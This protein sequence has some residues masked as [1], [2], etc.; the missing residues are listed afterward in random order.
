MKDVEIGV[1][2]GSGF[3]KLEG[4][5]N[6]KYIDVDTP[7]GKPTEKILIGEIEDKRVAF[8]SRHGIG[9][10]YNPSEVNYRANIYALK[11]LGVKRILSFAAVG[12]LKEEYAPQHI[13]IPDQYYDNTFKR[14]KTFFEKGIVAHVP[15]GNPFCPYLSDISYKIIKDL[16]LSVHKGGTYLN[17]EGP[18]FSTK[19]ES[20]A[21]RQLG[22]D[23]IGMTQA[24][25][26]KL[27]RE[28]EICF[29]SLCFVTDYD[30]WHE[31]FESVTVDMIIENFNKN[32]E[33]M[34]KIVKLLVK[35]IDSDTTNC[36]CANALQY[37]IVTAKDKIDKETY[38][39]LEIV[40]SK[41]FKEN[42]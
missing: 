28:L 26:A 41:Y 1:I 7:F 39:K 35:N 14:D 20:N 33:N 17:M 34:K 37:S 32:V 9:H 21:Y 40:L 3:Y 31:E 38:K 19:A 13:V 2:G 23:I 4:L 36:S 12:S 11:K 29:V 16:G 22:F 42:N 15:M 10:R 8:I 27:S 18:Q 5:S 6:G 24:I 25:E 30:C